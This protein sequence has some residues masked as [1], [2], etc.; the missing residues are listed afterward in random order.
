M[1][2][3]FFQAILVLMFKKIAGVLSKD[4]GIDLGTANTLV[5]VKDR[6]I[7]INEPSVVAFNNKT[8]RIIAIGEE[9][10]NMLGRTP[11][12]INVVKPLSEGVISDFEAAEE[13]LKYFIQKVHRETFNLIPR[14]KVVIAIPSKTTEVQKKSAQD[15]ALNAGARQVFLLEEPLAGALG[16]RLP[17]QEAQA[18]MVVDI[19][20]GTTDMALISLGGVVLKD[21]LKIAGD[22]LTQNIIDYVAQKFSLLIGERSAEKIKISIGSVFPLKQE[23][24]FNVRGRDLATGLPRAVVINNDEVREALEKPVHQIVSNIKGLIEKSPPELVADLMHQGILLV[25]GGSLL[26]GLPELIYRETEIPT[27][28]DDD[29]LTTICRGTG[30]ALENIKALKDVFVNV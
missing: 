1:T 6:G 15:A 27:R 30:F 21:S 25:G 11:V 16:A 9:A 22:R 19:G 8:G 18:S 5:Y 4:I 12:H 14:P 2:S 17:I 10:K 28:I 24:V 13:M 23:L 26:R 3:P 20:G 29:P 7:V